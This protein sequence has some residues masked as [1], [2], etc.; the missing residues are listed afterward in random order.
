[1]TRRRWRL[2]NVLTCTVISALGAGVMSL[3]TLI[4][5]IHAH[6]DQQRSEASK[7]LWEKRQAAYAELLAISARAATPRKTEEYLDLHQR[8]YDASG[9]IE[10]YGTSELASCTTTLRDTLYSCA[11]PNEPKPSEVC[12]VQRL[13]TLHV[14]LG[15]EARE[16]LVRTWDQHPKEFL[17]DRFG[18][19]PCGI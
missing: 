8:F 11:H 15:V 17:D 19:E 4:W 7:T 1:M 3:A 9:P 6:H 13:H 12:D 5:T 18:M 16:S 2:R 10:V 14:R